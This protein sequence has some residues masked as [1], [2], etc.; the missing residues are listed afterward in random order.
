VIVEIKHVIT[1]LDMSKHLD[2]TGEEAVYKLQG[3]L[4]HAGGSDGGHIFAYVRSETR[5]GRTV[6]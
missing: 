3:V 1:L 5:D 2:T 6:W 4:V